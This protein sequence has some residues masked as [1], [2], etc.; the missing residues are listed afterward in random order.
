MPIDRI[1]G[2]APPRRLQPIDLGV[3]VPA[4][5]PRSGPVARAPQVNQAQFEAAIWAAR[6]AGGAYGITFAA[7]RNGELL[8]SGAAGRHRDGIATL[9]T[10]DPLVIGSVTKTFIAATVLQLA[11]EGRLE[12]D[13]PVRDHLPNMTSISREITVR[14]LLDHTSGLAD[15]FNDATRTGLEQHPER[16]WTTAEVFET[17]HAPWYQPGDGWAYANTNYFLLGLLIQDVT[18]A[19]LADELQTRFLAPLDL[20]DTRLL[21]G[22]VDDGGP[23]SPAWATIF[24]ASGAMSA[25]ADDLAHWGDALY[26]GDI[27]SD[28]S[29][30]DMIALNSHDYG[31]GLQRI[32]LPGAL[33]YG[34]SGLL[35]TYTTLLVHLPEDD[36]TIALLVNRSHVDLG[37]MLTAK[38]PNGP[39]L[40]EL[41]GVEPPA[42]P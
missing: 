10:D 11:E 42:L 23:L 37:R 15:V 21:T 27:L 22:A 12:L 31:L 17:L 36:V 29:R 34:H 33:G 25:S 1:D 35:N 8:W 41:T 6:E 24:W 19:S 4:P 13:Q 39:S 2:P 16:A 18:G 7:V 9:A 14:Q 40:L 28:A 5:A 3:H 32:E 26:G 30:R 38:P 20:D